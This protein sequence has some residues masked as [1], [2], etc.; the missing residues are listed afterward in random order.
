MI[1]C[2]KG[3]KV[4]EQKENQRKV[5]LFPDTIS[6]FSLFIGVKEGRGVLGVLRKLII[7]GK[8]I[9][10]TNLRFFRFSKEKIYNLR[11]LCGE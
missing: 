10:F 4:K 9:I 6:F 8:K 3:E 2:V 11:K 1:I 7:K 5:V